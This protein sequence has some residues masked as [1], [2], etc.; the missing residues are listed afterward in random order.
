MSLQQNITRK[1]KR[2]KNY[3][4]TWQFVLNAE[5]NRTSHTTS[6]VQCASWLLM[7]R[8]VISQCSP[9]VSGHWRPRTRRWRHRPMT[10][11]ASARTRRCQRTTCEHAAWSVNTPRRRAA[12][13]RQ[14]WTWWRHTPHHV[15]T[16]LTTTTTTTT[17]VTCRCH[18]VTAPD[19]VTWPSLVPSVRRSRW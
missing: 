18:A 2:K 5:L 15:T 1:K 13:T 11:S 6:L 9:G 4:V 3:P 14:R 7:P 17:G 8:D 16:T 12:A 19:M 10:S